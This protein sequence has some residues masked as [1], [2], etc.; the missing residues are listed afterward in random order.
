MCMKNMWDDLWGNLSFRKRRGGFN[1]CGCLIIE[2][3]EG[4]VESNGI[5]GNSWIGVG[6]K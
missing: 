2:E 5:S 3:F 4:C 6:S 1:C